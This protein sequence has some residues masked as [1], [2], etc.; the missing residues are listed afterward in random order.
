MRNPDLIP[1]MKSLRDVDVQGKHQDDNRDPKG[2]L[3]FL[4]GAG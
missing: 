4:S 2:L 3:G 1:S